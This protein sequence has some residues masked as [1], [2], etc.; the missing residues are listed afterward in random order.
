MTEK[1]LHLLVLHGYAA[2]CKFYPITTIDIYFWDDVNYCHFC[3]FRKSHF[4]FASIS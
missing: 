1:M 3:S 2:T 4:I